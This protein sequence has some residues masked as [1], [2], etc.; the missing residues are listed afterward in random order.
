M[1]AGDA[2]S[3]LQ[4][5]VNVFPH[6]V[7]LASALCRVKLILSLL[8]LLTCDLIRYHNMCVAGQTLHVMTVELLDWSFSLD[9]RT[10]TCKR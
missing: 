10:R 9:L 1:T 7:C 2:T 4:C 5:V 3:N 8:S 6:C